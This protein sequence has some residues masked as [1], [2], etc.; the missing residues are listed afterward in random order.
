MRRVVG[1]LVAL[2]G[3]AMLLLAGYLRVASD[4][5]PGGMLLAFAPRWM[6]LL[7]W[8]VLLLLA[9]R[10][11]WRVTIVVLL[12][13]VVTSVGVAG[14]AVPTQ[15]ASDG[16]PVLR[17]VTYNTDGSVTLPMRIRRDLI[18]W[19]ADVVMLQ[20]CPRTLADSLRQIAGARVDVSDELCVLSRLPVVRFE[21]MPPSRGDT[22]RARAVRVDVQTVGGVISVVGLHNASPR[23]A[24]NAARA[25][26]FRLLDRS[27]AQR[28]RISQAMHRW[29]VATPHAAIV[30]GDFNMPESSRLLQRDWGAL[31]NAFSESGWGFG[32][33][34]HAGVFSVRIDHVFTTTALRPV[35][36]R[37][38]DGFPSEHQPLMVE[39]ARAAE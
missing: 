24:L 35:S 37:V 32:Y 4:L 33:T 17:L 11:S 1:I 10:R 14:F 31:R 28:G 36:A 5:T 21:A 18:D 2:Y 30:A 38:L 16:A 39:V 22:R 29:S 3:A 13:V 20:D 27:I 26:N 12:G 7:P 34:M 25:R 15:P 19:N 8:A 9:V 23:A 6:F